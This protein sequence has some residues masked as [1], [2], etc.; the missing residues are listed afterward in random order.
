ML[1]LF[2]I[3]AVAVYLVSK[4]DMTHFAQARAQVGLASMASSTSTRS[5]NPAAPRLAIEGTQRPRFRSTKFV[6]AFGVNPRAV[7]DIRIYAHFGG[8][9]QF[10]AAISKLLAEIYAHGAAVG[11]E[12]M[13]LLC[14]GRGLKEGE[15]IY[16]A[17]VDSRPEPRIV[18]FIDKLRLA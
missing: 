18:A 6:K 9:E 2:C 12:I 13:G 16:F 1:E 3:L 14:H 8:L 17:L 4:L 7:H 5:E 15:A 10:P 11:T